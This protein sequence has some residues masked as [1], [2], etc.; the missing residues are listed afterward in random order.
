VQTAGR[1]R[2][3]RFNRKSHCNPVNSASND[4]NTGPAI[5]ANVGISSCQEGDDPNREKVSST[6]NMD[7][8]GKANDAVPHLAITRFTTV[9]FKNY[10]YDDYSVVFN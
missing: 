4:T 2:G 7:A 3:F 8:T 9:P 1:N 5:P 6:E 10:L